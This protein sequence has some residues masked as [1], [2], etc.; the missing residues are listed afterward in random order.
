[1][2][3]QLRERQV[4]L[5][6]EETQNA[7]LVPM[8]ALLIFATPR[9]IKH[10]GCTN[11]RPKIDSPTWESIT[12]LRWPEQCYDIRDECEEVFL[13]NE[14]TGLSKGVPARG[15]VHSTRV[16]YAVYEAIDE[17]NTESRRKISR[18]RRSGKKTLYGFDLREA[19]RTED[20]Y[21]RRLKCTASMRV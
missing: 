14:Q 6:D 5:Y 18:E 12:E 10:F 7:T 17:S 1:M 11:C 13:E 19:I 4:I 20:V 21:I 15:V 16:V 9:Y 2:F 8:I 3:S